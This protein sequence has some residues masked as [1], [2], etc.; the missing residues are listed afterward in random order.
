M[1]LT[2]AGFIVAD[3][4]AIFGIGP[5]EEAAWADLRRGMKLA[6]IP[7]ESEVEKEDSFCP[8]YWTEDRFHAYPATAALLEQVEQRGG[9]ISW[10]TVNRVACT[11]E[12]SEAAEDQE[13][14]A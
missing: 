2:Q 14:A 6:K 4:A 8:A 5:T 3:D 9:A 10:D 12:E 1:T 13:N 7:H 11:T